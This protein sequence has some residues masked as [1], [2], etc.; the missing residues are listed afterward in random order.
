MPPRQPGTNRNPR[1]R[2]VTVMPS[3]W[4][5]VGLVLLVLMLVFVIS[6]D[7]A[8]IDYSDFLTL[9]QKGNVDNVALGTE[10][11]RGEVKDVEKLPDELKKKFRGA[12]K[13]FHTSVPPGIK[14]QSPLI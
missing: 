11:I 6:N 4:M 2:P 7:G 10:R 9:V 8:A 3:G 5:L 12:S 14:D 13:A 1:R